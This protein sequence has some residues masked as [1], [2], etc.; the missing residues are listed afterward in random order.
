MEKVGFGGSC[1]WCTEAVFQSLNGVEKVEQGW[2]SSFEPNDRFSEAVVVHFDPNQIDLSTLIAIHLHTHSCT[3]DH[4][5][6]RKYRSAVYTHSEDQM[7][8]ANEVIA[9]LAKEFEGKIITQVLPFQEFKLS[10]ELGQ[11]AHV[12]RERIVHW[13]AAQGRLHDVSTVETEIDEIC[14]DTGRNG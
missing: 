2:I 10:Q 13:L 4:S 12:Q 3:A 1:H 8:D 14:R 5:M 6:R 11:A 9:S 7:T